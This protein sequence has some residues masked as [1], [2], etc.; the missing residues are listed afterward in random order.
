MMN[1]DRLAK[2]PMDDGIEPDESEE[3]REK[4]GKKE[5]RK[6]GGKEGKWEGVS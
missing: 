4:E 3:G 1:C 2:L 6:E 5:R